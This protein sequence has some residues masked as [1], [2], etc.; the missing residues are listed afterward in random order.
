MTAMSDAERLRQRSKRMLELASRA[1]CEGAESS[2]GTE[3]TSRDVRLESASEG[4]AAECR[5]E[6]PIGFSENNI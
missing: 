3:L 5:L 6:A 2:S 4:K 1:Y